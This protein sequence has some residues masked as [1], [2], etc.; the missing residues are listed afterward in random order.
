MVQDK[1]AIL[2]KDIPPISDYDKQFVVPLQCRDYNTFEYQGDAVIHGRP[3]PLYRGSAPPRSSCC[4]I[5]DKLF[6]TFT[7]TSQLATF[8]NFKT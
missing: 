2:L 1:T 6:A 3:S 5:T 4:L 8:M 7:F